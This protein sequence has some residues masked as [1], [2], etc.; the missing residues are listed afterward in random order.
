MII[1]EFNQRYEG[2][3][4]GLI[5]LS[6][7]PILCI[8]SLAEVYLKALYTIKEHIRLEGRKS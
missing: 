1:S 3:E 2:V 7:C 8:S 6:A 4:L 5:N